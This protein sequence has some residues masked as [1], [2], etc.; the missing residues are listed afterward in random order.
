M[1]LR[2]VKWELQLRCDLSLIIARESEKCYSTFDIMLGD[3]PRKPNI[4]LTVSRIGS[5]RAKF[6]QPDLHG[7][8]AEEHG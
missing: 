6:W 8:T 5:V 7:G 1:K 3:E 4:F 2:S